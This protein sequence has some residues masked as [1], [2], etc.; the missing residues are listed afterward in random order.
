MP[1]SARVENSL[2]TREAENSLNTCK[3]SSLL[4][5]DRVCRTLHFY[6][7]SQPLRLAFQPTLRSID[8]KRFAFCYTFRS[9]STPSLSLVSVPMMSR[10]SSQVW[11]PTPQAT[12]RSPARDNINQL[13]LLIDGDAVVMVCLQQ[14]PLQ[15]HVQPNSVF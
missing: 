1:S 8:L 4:A 11:L 12:V 15:L 3:E 7:C 2:S 9:L 14:H 5:S 6:R 13:G 10:L